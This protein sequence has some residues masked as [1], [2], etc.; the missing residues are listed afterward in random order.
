[1]YA[2]SLGGTASGRVELGLVTLAVQASVFLPN[3]IGETPASPVIALAVLRKASHPHDASV[4]ALVY[5]AAPEFY[6]FTN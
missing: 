3:V 1:M 2:S 4:Y 6:R 5:S